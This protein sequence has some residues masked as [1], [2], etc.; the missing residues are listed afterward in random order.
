MLKDHYLYQILSLNAKEKFAVDSTLEQR[1]LIDVLHARYGEEHTRRQIKRWIEQNGCSLNGELVTQAT[2]P[3][4]ESDELVCRPELFEQ[5]IRP[6]RGLE[7]SRIL[8]EDDALLV[9]DKPAGIACEGKGG[10]LEL[11][12]HHF[13]SIQLGHRLDAPTSG[14]L[15]LGKTVDDA[16]ALHLLFRERKVHKTYLCLVDGVPGS[17]SGEIRKA[18]DRAKGPRGQVRMEENK[19]GKLAITRWERLAAGERSAAILCYPETGRTHQIRVHM[20]GMG[21]AIL[22]DSSYCRRF[23]C[24]TIPT[25]VLLHAYELRFPHPVHGEILSF[26]APIPA[27]LRRTAET[28]KMELP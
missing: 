22:G 12:Q 10:M 16:K 1:R 8:Y 7:E 3:V 9:Y 17:G 24:S 11:L 4:K 27:D 5:L 18:L 21:H 14:L 19:R 2:R 15:L 13:P 25:R 26:T 28:L 6:T 20:S 23:R